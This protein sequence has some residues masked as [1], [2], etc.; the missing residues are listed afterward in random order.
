MKNINGEACNEVM[1][2]EHATIPSKNMI[3][4]KVL[5]R[6]ILTNFF[7]WKD[8]FCLEEKTKF[9]SKES[10]VRDESLKQ[11]SFSNEV[12]KKVGASDNSFKEC[13]FC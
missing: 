13:D 10:G 12:K 11:L 3:F 1:K 2:V 6:P 5:T 7:K 4:A 8:V 9:W